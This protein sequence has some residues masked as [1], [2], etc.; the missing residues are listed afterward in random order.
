MR[1][2]GSTDTIFIV[3]TDRPGD[4]RTLEYA[5][6]D[7]M[8][9]TDLMGNAVKSKDRPSGQARVEIDDAAG[10]IYLRW[11]A[12]SRGMLHPD[13]ALPSPRIARGTFPSRH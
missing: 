8:S 3:W 13:P 10:P 7:L 9:A 2:D 4:R 5:K 11:P 1:L 6:H 12:G